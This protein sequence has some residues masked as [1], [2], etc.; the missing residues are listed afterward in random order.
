[1]KSDPPKSV[2]II[3]PDAMGD[4]VLFSPT[5]LA[6]RNGWPKAKI[7]VLIRSTFKDIAQLLV[8]S[9]ECERPDRIIK[10][11]RS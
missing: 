7:S 2:L 10:T 11:T 3:R 1:L 6:L 8:S 5:L 9:V 4:L